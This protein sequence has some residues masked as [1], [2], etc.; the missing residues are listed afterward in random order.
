MSLAPKEFYARL[1]SLIAEMPDL[2][3]GPITLEVHQWLG[4]AAALVE[5]TGDWINFHQ[6]K[7]YSQNL[8]GP[9]RETN[10][11]AIATI[12]YEAHAKAELNAP[13]AVRGTFIA[14]GH[15]FDAFAAVGNILK[16]AQT[17]I[18]FV[19]A[20]ADE[21]VLFDYAVL[22]PE[23]VTVRVLAEAY[24]KQSLKP[25]AARWGQQFGNRHLLVRIAPDK[26]LHDREIFI[27]GNKAW[28][29]GQSLKD[30]ATRSLT[31]LSLVDAD[32]GAR[33]IAAYRDIWNASQSL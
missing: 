3:N 16:T 8:G 31:A 4:R 17:D 9:L 6:L 28:S 14:A 25:A 23:N 13:A 19:D 18:L 20:Y 30:L 10:A 2:A 26:A 15:T 33:K 22:A 32:L 24:Y 5:L 27:D 12:V 7:V 29:V 11:Q 1:N 21:T